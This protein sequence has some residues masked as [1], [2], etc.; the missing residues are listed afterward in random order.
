M[1]PPATTSEGR[2]CIGSYLYVRYEIVLPIS[3][4]AVVYLIARAA[5]AAA[6][7]CD[8]TVSGEHHKSTPSFEKLPRHLG[9]LMVK[10]ISVN[11]AYTSRVIVR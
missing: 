11:T 4:V 8:V 9:Q 1:R 6:T 5:A 7:D 10:A 3:P 2:R